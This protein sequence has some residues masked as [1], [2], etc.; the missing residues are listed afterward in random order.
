MTIYNFQTEKNK[1][2]S[3]AK[4]SSC[5][6]SKYLYN[7]Y[8]LLKI[9][10][11]SRQT[12]LHFIPIMPMVL[13]FDILFFTGAIMDSMRGKFFQHIL[14]FCL[15][16]WTQKQQKVNN[17]TWIGNSTGKR[18]A[19]YRFIQVTTSYCCFCGQSLPFCIVLFS[20]IDLI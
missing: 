3:I 15:R 7:S 8:F 14:V 9:I 4:R 13:N 18:Q 12:G 20:S 5:K 11:V 1:Y 19:S 16:L 6:S 2:N 10:N 17:G